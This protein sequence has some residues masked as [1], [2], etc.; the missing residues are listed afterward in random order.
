M[1]PKRPKVASWSC[2]KD[3]NKRGE[4]PLDDSERVSL[5]KVLDRVD[6]AH[7]KQHP[8]CSARL[9]IGFPDPK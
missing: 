1:V 8:G 7:M 3:P 6:T 9:K 5:G 4:V 2:T